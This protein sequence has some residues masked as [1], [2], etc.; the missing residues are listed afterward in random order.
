MD[1][2]LTPSPRPHGGQRMISAT[3]LVLEAFV[4]FFA[5]LVAHQ[6][7]PGDRA[8]T[9]TW[10]LLTAFGLLACG[11]LLKRG[12]WP[13]WLGLAFQLP[14]ILLGLQVSAM[15]VIG[16]GFALMY[17]YGV[18]K[19]HQ[20]DAEKDAVDAKVRAGWAEQDNAGD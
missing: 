16:I 18:V 13:Y 17:A 19:G 11:G 1:L 2:D 4:V 9:W 6:L 12:A 10:G 7:V 20:M 14:V 5:V 15:W 3:V 8:L